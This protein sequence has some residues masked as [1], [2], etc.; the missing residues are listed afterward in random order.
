MSGRSEPFE[1]LP[2]EGI[3]EARF[4]ESRSVHRERL[5][6]HVAFERFPGSV[7]DSYYDMTLI[8]A[9]DANNR[10]IEID[11]SDSIEVLWRGISLVGRPLGEVLNELANEGFRPDVFELESLKFSELGLSLYTPAVEELE[12]DVKHVILEPRG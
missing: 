8:L 9:Y 4:G 2:G 10:L 12:E 5:G 7:L 6:N 11:I 3:S 1:V